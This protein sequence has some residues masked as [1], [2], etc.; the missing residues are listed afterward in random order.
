[1]FDNDLLRLRLDLRSGLHKR[2]LGEVD[3]DD[4][5]EDVENDADEIVEEE[6]SSDSAVFVFNSFLSAN[7]S[8]LL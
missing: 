4:V 2:F 8:Q 5:I 6:F 7:E 3:A 1:M